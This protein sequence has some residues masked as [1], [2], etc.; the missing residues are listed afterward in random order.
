[1]ELQWNKWDVLNVEM[2]FILVCMAC[3]ILFLSSFVDDDN[4]VA[5]NTA[6]CKIYRDTWARGKWQENTKEN[7]VM[8][9]SFSIIKPTRCA[10]L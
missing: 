8:L 4:S 2:A 3:G 7:I 5:V 1:M 10:N 9:V 6:W